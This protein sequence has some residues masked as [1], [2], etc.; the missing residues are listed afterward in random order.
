MVLFPETFGAN[1]TLK[2]L[3]I[4]D[5]VVERIDSM[6]VLAPVVDPLSWSAQGVLST[7]AQ[8]FALM[9][10]AGWKVLIGQ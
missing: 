3:K 7:E 5:A 10:F 8:S 2:A 1:Y 6:G 4:R 9:M